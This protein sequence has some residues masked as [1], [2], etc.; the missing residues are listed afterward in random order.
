MDE[1]RI[2]YTDVAIFIFLIVAKLIPNGILD[3]LLFVK[4]VLLALI[5]HVKYAYEELD[6]IEIIIV[7]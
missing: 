7:Q 1:L 2:Y 4:C 5:W 6:P 3:S